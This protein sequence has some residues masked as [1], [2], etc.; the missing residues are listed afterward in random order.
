MLGDALGFSRPGLV[1]VVVPD[2]LLRRAVVRVARSGGFRVVSVETL[3]HG[4]TLMRGS[5]VTTSVLVVDLPAHDSEIQ[6]LLAGLRLWYPDVPALLLTDL[7]V[8]GD[9]FAADGLP[10]V[11]W[12]EKPFTRAEF[13]G[14]LRRAI[15]SR[16]VAP[17]AGTEVR[18]CLP[19]GC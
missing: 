7:A 19:G 3:A 14:A 16:D 15:L 1:L 6:E 9:R 10:L 4:R 13:L 11:Y 17:E 5:R 8:V 12:I 18:V 2:A